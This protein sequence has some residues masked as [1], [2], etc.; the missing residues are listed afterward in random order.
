MKDWLDKLTNLAA[1]Q[2]DENVLKQA[3][4]D[5]ADQAGFGG[6]AYLYIRPSHTIAASNYHPEWRSTYFQRNYE[7]V[8]PVVKRSMSFNKAFTWS[9]DDERPRLDKEGRA[10]YAHAAD[11]GIRSGLTISIRT[12]NGSTSMFTLASEKTVIEL[13]RDI[14]AVSAVA[15]VGQ[16]HARMS[17]LPLTASEQHPGWLDPKEAAY[18]RWI[19]VGKTMEETACVEGVKYNSVKSKLEEMRKRLSART[20]PQLVALAIRA[21]LI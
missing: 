16:L 20:M 3:L 4:A 18:L 5:F 17:F 6:Y 11:F 21:G 19:A 2:G 14:D 9:A 1:A 10:F 8:D 15:A 13:G 7:K 12:A